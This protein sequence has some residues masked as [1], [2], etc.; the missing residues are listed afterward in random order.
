MKKNNI[1]TLFIFLFSLVTILNFNLPVSAEGEIVATING[2]DITADQFVE[3]AKYKRFET[4]QE[5]NY[6]V[7]IYSAYGIPIDD[8]FNQQYITLL[9]DEGKK[10]FGQQV[11]NQLTYDV[12][13]DEE[14]KKANIS[15]SDQEVT[16]KLMDMFGFGEDSATETPTETGLGAESADVVES[17]PEINKE[18]EFQATFDEFFA[19]NIGDLFSKDFFKKQVYYMLLENKLL[20]ES[21]FKDQKFEAEMVSARH[22]LVDTEE[23][24]QEVLDKLSAGENWDDLAKEYSQ[25]T[26]NKDSS[27]ELGWF[28]RGTMAL[29]F[30]EAAFAMEPGTISKPVKTDFGYHIIASDGKEVR[31]LEGEAL[32]NAKYAAYKTW[33]EKVT[34]ESKLET[35]DNWIDLVPSEPVFT[36]VQPQ[37]TA[38]VAPEAE[39]NTV[40]ESTAEAESVQ[41]EVTATT[42][43]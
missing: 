43:P 33:Y 35:Y 41:E 29:P 6:I 1:I 32:D 23:K 36:P 40:T 8:S 5:Y 14:A 26:A 18:L 30:E 25:D 31:P 21:V 17:E 28:A 42:A 39:T 22:I 38:T 27:G 34:S 24:A 4:I 15:V 10:D 11:L 13:L 20:E 12:I 19:N 2:V 37:P 9:G 7:Q 3:A 16:D